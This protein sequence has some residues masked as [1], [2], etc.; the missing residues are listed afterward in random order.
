MRERQTPSRADTISRV[1]PACGQ[2]F[3]A[4]ESKSMPFCSPRCQLID[5]GR[6]L[7]EDIGVPHEGD[8]GDVP[9]EYR[10]SAQE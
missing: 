5:L 6:W 1:C 4:D 10:E 8:P 2:K 9:V 3:L 7:E